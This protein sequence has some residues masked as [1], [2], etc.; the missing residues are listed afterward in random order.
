MSN[1]FLYRIGRGLDMDIRIDDST[2]S[3]VHAELVVTAN[4]TYYLTDC[5][6]SGGSYVARNGKWVPITQ[7]FIA[8]MDAILLGRYQ[9]SAEQLMAMSK[10][11]SRVSRK[12]DLPRGQVHRNVDTGEII[13][14]VD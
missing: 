2:V 4:R 10:R 6:S 9:T 5:D 11:D 1:F 8:P 12:D 3:R 13:G 7:D 14:D